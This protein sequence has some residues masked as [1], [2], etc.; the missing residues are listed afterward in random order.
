[1]SANAI[2]EAVDVLRELREPYAC[3]TTSHEGEPDAAEFGR[4]VRGL[5]S[6]ISALT[7]AQQ[8]EHDERFTCVCQLERKFNMYPTTTQQQGQAAPPSAPVGVG[9]KMAEVV[10]FLMGEA[11]LEGRWFDEPGDPH[12]GGAYWWRKHLT[13]AIAAQQQEGE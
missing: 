13:E 5:D 11:P 12:V 8:P 2:D 4:I 6:A 10:R 9:G 3:M 1:M 7:A